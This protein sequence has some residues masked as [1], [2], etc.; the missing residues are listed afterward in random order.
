MKQPELA[1]TTGGNIRQQNPLE[2]HFSSFLEAKQTPPKTHQFHSC[3]LGV[4]SQ[5]N[6]NTIIQSSII[7]NTQY[8]YFIYMTF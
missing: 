4:C 5:T 2:K 3:V 1:H 7:H 8:V 6:L